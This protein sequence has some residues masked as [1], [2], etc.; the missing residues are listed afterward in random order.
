MRNIVFVVA[1]I[2]LLAACS[3]AKQAGHSESKPALPAPGGPTID[4]PMLSEPGLWR[5]TTTVNGRRVV[6]VYRACVDAASQKADDIFEN[7][8]EMGCDTP[9]RRAIANGYAYELVCRKDGVKTQV[10]GEVK[11][12]ARRVEMTST[13]RVTGPDGATVPPANVG[14]E[15]VYVGPCPVDM[16]PGQSVQEGVQAP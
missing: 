4:G 14:V 12:D 6:G 8:S 7:P 1:P 9:V 10:A 16:K 5:T 15:S 2:L 13:T 3:G 11:G